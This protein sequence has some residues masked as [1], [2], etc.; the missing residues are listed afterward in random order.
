MPSKYMTRSC[1]MITKEQY[2][3]LKPYWDH[4]RLQAFNKEVLHEK[5]IDMIKMLTEKLE[6]DEEE[7]NSDVIFDAMWADMSQ[8]DWQEPR[9]GWRPKDPSLMLWYEIE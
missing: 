3:E 7:F 6:C 5:I 8:D 2:E 1:S 9:F 4:Q